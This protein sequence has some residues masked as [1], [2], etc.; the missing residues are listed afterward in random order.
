MKEPQSGLMRPA[1]YARHRQVHRSHITRLAQR[2]ILVMRGKLVDVAASD[3]VLD[4]QPV[5][6]EH[7][8]PAASRP[9]IDPPAG[10]PSAAQSSPYAA[11]KTADMVYRAKLRKLEF[12]TRQKTLV[13]ADEVASATEAR[14]R[15]DRDALLSWPARVAAE[16]AAELGTDERSTHAALDKHIRQ[17]MRERSGAQVAEE[18]R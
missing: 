1:E 13:D 5:D 8:R 2:G 18:E 15:G 7:P 10:Q 9:P 12:E 17:F 14:I 6:V 4:D 11:A 16:M 3:A